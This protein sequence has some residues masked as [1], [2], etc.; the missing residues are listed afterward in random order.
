MT[1]EDLRIFLYYCIL[2]PIV[3]SFAIVGIAEMISVTFNIPLL[4]SN[5]IKTFIESLLI[6]FLWSVFRTYKT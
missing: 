2:L 3:V 6:T 1:D 4:K 5:V